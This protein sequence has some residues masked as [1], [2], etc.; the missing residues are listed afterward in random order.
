MHA[1]SYTENDNES[2]AMPIVQLEKPADRS[3]SEWFSELRSWLDLHRCEARGF[4]LAG[5]RLD[6]KVYVISF[7]D[8][9]KARQFSQN[10]AQYDPLVRRPTLSER[11]SIA[12]EA[13]G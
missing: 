7:K 11:S 10:F 5:R 4:T 6:R 13:I 2:S 9:G 8:A 12:A 3:L 1:L